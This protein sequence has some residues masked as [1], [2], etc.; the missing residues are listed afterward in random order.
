MIFKDQLGEEIELK[1][2]PERIISLVPSQT[3]LLYDLGVK[4]LAQTIFC[5]HPKSEFKTAQ[6]IGGTKKLNISKIKSLQPDLIIGNKEENVREQIEE[7]RS[8]APVW[9]SDVNS[10]SGGVE[11]I[12]SVAQMV[13][14]EAESKEMISRIESGINRLITEKPKTKSCIYLIW[15]Q[16]MM[17]V[18]TETYINDVLRL[19]GFE[20]RI[21]VSRYPEIS[22][23]EIAQLNPDE[24]L[25][26]TEPF[27]FKEEHVAE[28][29][30]RFLASKVRLI[31]AEIISWYGSRMKS[32]PDYL[33]EFRSL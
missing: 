32:L 25:L 21:Q 13:G 24:I 10:V 6:K 23:A 4:P 11:M 26:S 7:L 1:S 28:F 8:I 20:N 33:L 22:D 16:P 15:N 5:I 29:Q 12:R 31:D 19:G 14:K 30:K 9:M 18:G 17:A 2:V 3:E 27:P